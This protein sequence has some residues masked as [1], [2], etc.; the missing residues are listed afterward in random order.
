[1]F[2]RKLCEFLANLDR[3][4][5]RRGDVV[6]LFLISEQ[7]EDKNKNIV[8]WSI[9]ISMLYDHLTARENGQKLSGETR[10]TARAASWVKVEDPCQGWTGSLMI[11]LTLFS[12]YIP[13]A[14]NLGFRM[15]SIVRAILAL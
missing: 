6:E 14:V 10:A 15:F 12:P 13:S 11:T 2:S 4:Q 9:D 5:C 3:C 1:V 7:L 8:R